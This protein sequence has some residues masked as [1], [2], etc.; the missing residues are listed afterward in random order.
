MCASESH[1][2]SRFRKVESSADS[3]VMGSAKKVDGRGGDDLIVGKS[4][5]DILLGRAGN[6]F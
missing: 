6:A 1:V 5:D 4:G 3:F 2:A